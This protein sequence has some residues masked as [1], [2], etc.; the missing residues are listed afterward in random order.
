MADSTATAATPPPVQPQPQGHK[1]K[2]DEP[3]DPL[4]PCIHAN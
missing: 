1:K 4:P 3:T 2:S